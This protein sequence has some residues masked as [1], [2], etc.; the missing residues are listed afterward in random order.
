MTDDDRA[1]R[2]AADGCCRRSG[3]DPC[4]RPGIACTVADGARRAD[5]CRAGSARGSGGPAPA[6]RGGRAGADEPAAELWELCVRLGAERTVLLQNSQE[7]A[8]RAAGRRRVGGSGGGGMHC[9]ARCLRRCGGL[10]LRRPRW[11]SPPRRSAT[12]RRCWSTA[13]RGV[14]GLDVLLGIENV[15]GCAGP[16]S[17]CPTGRLPGRRAA[18]GA[19]Q[20]AVGGAGGRA[21]SRARGSRRRSLRRCSMSSWTPDDGAG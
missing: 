1:R 7:R 16:T 8:D 18:A 17:P 20:G 12:P 5:R 15:P 11:P 4:R 2:R 13:I 9:C 6:L 21:V 3:G 10:G 19:A 14:P